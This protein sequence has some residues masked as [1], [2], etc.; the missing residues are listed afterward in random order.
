M[1]VSDVMTTNPVTIGPNDTVRL[2]IACMESID[3]RRLPVLDDSGGLIGIITDRGVRLGLHSTYISHL[4][5]PDNEILDSIKVR[6][7]MTPAPVIVE[8]TT[9]I[10]Q[11][12]SLMIRY[13]IGGPARHLR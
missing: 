10:V 6:D 9:D 4:S 12:T 2:A 1:F 3:C 7:C 8:P 5:K 11:A 13:H